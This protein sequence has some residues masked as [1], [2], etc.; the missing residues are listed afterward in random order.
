MSRG[1]L[2]AI[3]SIDHPRPRFAACPI[4]NGQGRQMTKFG[5]IFFAIP[6]AVFGIQDLIHG[7]WMGGLPP[8]PPWTPGGHIFAYVMGVVLIAISISLIA[9]KEA[10]FSAT[11]LGL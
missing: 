8:V 6:L 3:R 9:K 7:R 5:R 2:V 10:R 1:S 4:V 11:I